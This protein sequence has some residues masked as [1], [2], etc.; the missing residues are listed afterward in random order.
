MNMD[1]NHSARRAFIDY[2]RRNGLA[3]TPQRSVIVEMF[4]H[5]RGHLTTE[6]LYDLVRERD[7]G[8]GQATVYRTV[9]LLAEAGLVEALDMGDGVTRYEWCYGAEHH[10]HL[11]CIRCGRKTEIVDQEIERRQEE[12]A[13]G[14]GFS[15][16][17]HRMVLF[18]VCPD[19]RGRGGG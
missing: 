8:M 15:L 17:R 2:L 14:H 18:G 5:T 1:T 13:R 9:K 12:L 10:D 6:Q 19:C 16:T 11:V 4:L 3:L 7:P